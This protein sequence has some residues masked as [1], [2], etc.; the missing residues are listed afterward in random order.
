MM[1][2]IKSHLIAWDQGE[3][4]KRGGKMQRGPGVPCPQEEEIVQR[5]V[6]GE[7]FS[8]DLTHHIA[9]CERCQEKVAVYQRLNA[10]LVQK[11]YRFDCPSSETLSY[12]CAGLLE[13]T[14]ADETEGHLR[15]CP[16][17]AEEVE[18]THTF[19]QAEQFKDS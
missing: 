17:C 16:L 4:Q 18:Q 14:R 12:Y 3:S 11:L 7:P 15:V 13:K 5:A 8:D 10:S 2:F 19:L 6:A 9:R 1:V